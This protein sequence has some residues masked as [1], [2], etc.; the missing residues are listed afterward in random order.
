MKVRI[1]PDAE[2]DLSQAA[3]FYDAQHHGASDYFTHG[4]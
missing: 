4:S 2:S 3:D 1:L